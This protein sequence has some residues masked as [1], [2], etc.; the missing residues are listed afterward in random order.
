MIDEAAARFAEADYAVVE[1]SRRRLHELARMQVSEM[2]RYTDDPD[3]TLEDRRHL[4]DTIAARSRK[5]DKPASKTFRIGRPALSLRPILF[6]PLA[7]MALAVIALGFAWH[8]T[9]PATGILQANATVTWQRQN[10]SRIIQRFSVGTI[11]RIVAHRNGL[12]V[13]EGWEPRRGYTLTGFADPNLV[14]LRR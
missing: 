6:V 9:P 7:I 3:L 1:I 13:I 4:R 12:F 10:G 11:M 14:R 5:A 2:A 8:N